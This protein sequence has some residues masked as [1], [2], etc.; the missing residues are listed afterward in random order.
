MEIMEFLKKGAKGVISC[1]DCK[2]FIYNQQKLNYYMAKKH[3]P[4]SSKL[5]TVFPSY[6]QEFLN[7]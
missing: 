4:S 2:S 3:E 5:S 1:P 6:E 7:Y